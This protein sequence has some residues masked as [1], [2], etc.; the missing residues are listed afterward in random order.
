M[1]IDF[2]KASVGN[3]FTCLDRVR[4]NGGTVRLSEKISGMS[5]CIT[6]FSFLLLMNLMAY[7]LLMMERSTIQPATFDRVLNLQ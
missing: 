2:E 7:R 6:E 5:S 1:L 3:I 4:I